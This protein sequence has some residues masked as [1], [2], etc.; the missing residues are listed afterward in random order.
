MKEVV[1][2]NLLKYQMQKKTKDEYNKDFSH[3]KKLKI[4]L[5][6]TYSKDEMDIWP[7][8]LK[9]FEPDFSNNSFINNN[10][11]VSFFYTDKP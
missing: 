2:K 9:K 8:I 1:N 10:S 11:E 4:E 5:K 7:N 6:K 3:K